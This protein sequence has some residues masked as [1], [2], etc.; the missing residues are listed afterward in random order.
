[1]ATSMVLES[2]RKQNGTN[3][4]R[5]VQERTGGEDHPAGAARHSASSASLFA[6]LGVAS[7]DA[8]HAVTF[9]SR[10]IMDCMLVKPVLSRFS[11]FLIQIQV[12]VIQRSSTELSQCLL[13]LEHLAALRSG[14][15]EVGQL[16]FK[17]RSVLELLELPHFLLPRLCLHHSHGLARFPRNGS[18]IAEHSSLPF[19]SPLAA[20][21]IIDYLTVFGQKI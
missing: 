1:M 18:A 7:T 8:A 13:L 20:K 15:G 16:G 10:L 14:F 9:K 5:E 21:R 11:M 4:R 2:P 3:D 19:A 12:V 6:E 17:H